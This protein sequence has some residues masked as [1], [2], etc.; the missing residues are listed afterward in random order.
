MNYLD[1]IKLHHCFLS[2]SNAN[3]TFYISLW[4][5]V[6]RDGLIDDIDITFFEAKHPTIN[7]HNLIFDKNIIPLSIFQ[8]IH[9]SNFFPVTQ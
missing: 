3:Q 8:F 5:G 2:F 9:L 6:L 1:S 7:N 4:N